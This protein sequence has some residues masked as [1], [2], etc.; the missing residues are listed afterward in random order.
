MKTRTTRWY[1]A[2]GYASL[3]AVKWG[4]LVAAMV[5][6][7]AGGSKGT[8][9]APMLEP[10]AEPEATGPSENPSVEVPNE[11]TPDFVDPNMS[12]ELPRPGLVFEQPACADGV[13]TTISGTVYAPSGTLPLYNAMVYVP[14]VEL[15][16]F[17][18]GVSCSCEVSG[19]PIVATITDSSGH[20]VL[21]N[22]PVGE[23]IPLV[24]QVGKWRRTFQLGAVSSCS[25][26]VVPDKTLLLPRNQS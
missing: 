24:I 18:P 22:A 4:A 21:E 14:R 12:G 8:T 17:T 20:F 15:A 6:C 3:A 23:A 5:A 1:G 19:E 25:E 11:V 2:G 7:S 10:E 16:P 9:G 26:T 13:T